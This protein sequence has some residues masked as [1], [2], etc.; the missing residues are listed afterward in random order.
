[1]LNPNSENDWTTV[2]FSKTAKQ[3]TA[4]MSSAQGVASLKAAGVV[5]TEKRFA[6]GSNTSSAQTGSSMRRL[7]ESTDEYSHSTV[8]RSLA[9]AIAQARQSKKMT[10]KD[11]AK[12]INESAQIVQQ[13]E[14]GTAIPN[15]QI[16]NKLDRALGIHLPRGKK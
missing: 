16:V 14:S 4:G 9:I 6:A 3:K 8:D 5:S 10:Q 12:A 11:L 7:D 1:M 13:Y 2:T 15:P